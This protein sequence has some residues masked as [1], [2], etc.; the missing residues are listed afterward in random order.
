MKEE[1][2]VTSIARVWFLYSEEALYTHTLAQ[3]RTIFFSYAFQA[4]RI[5]GSFTAH[6]SVCL[7]M[8]ESVSGKDES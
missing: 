6:N 4:H 7:F 5:T 3:L 1:N 8:A 2:F